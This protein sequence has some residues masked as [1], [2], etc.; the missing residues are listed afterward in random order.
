MQHGGL[1]GFT[2]MARPGN[3]DK[4]GVIQKRGKEQAHRLFLQ[5]RS[6]LV[7]SFSSMGTGVRY[8]PPKPDAV[9]L[10]CQSRRTET[11]SSSVGTSRVSLNVTSWMFNAIPH[12]PTNLSRHYGEGTQVPRAF[13]PCSNVISN[14]F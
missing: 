5:N 10:R 12:L 2:V 11:Q 8:H 1:L 9:F 6:R 4:R 3:S 7:Q 14:L 13:L